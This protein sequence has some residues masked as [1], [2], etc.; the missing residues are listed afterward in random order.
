M[1]EGLSP[2]A[3]PLSSQ[4][5]GGGGLSPQPPWPAFRSPGTDLPPPSRGFGS[6]WS[7]TRVGVPPCVKAGV[8]ALAVPKALLIGGLGPGNP[9]PSVLRSPPPLPFPFPPI[10]APLPSSLS[11][12]DG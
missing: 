2:E 10:L 7:H 8:W 3:V 6:R 12:G 11:L 5:P 4:L 9:V 1:N